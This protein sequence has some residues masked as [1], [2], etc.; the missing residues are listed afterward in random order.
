M[1]INIHKAIKLACISLFVTSHLNAQQFQATRHHFSTEDGLASNAIAQIVQDDYGYIWMATWNGLS[2]FDG[3]NF[4]NYK[5]GP[6]SHVRNLHN[7]ISQLEVDNQQNIWL[8][9]YDSRVFVMKRATD[10]IINPFEEISGSEDYRTSRRLTVTSS[11]DV[12]VVVDGVGLYKLRMTPEGIKSQLITTGDLSVSSIAEGY[13]DDIWLG[14]NQGVHRMDVSNLTIERKGLFLDEDITCIFSNGYNIY[15]GSKSGKILSFSYGQ[16]PQEI[17]SGGD[18]IGNL[19]VDSHG[20]IWFADSRMGVTKLDPD[21]KQEKFFTQVV[22][23]PD[24][25]GYGGLLAE[26]NGVVWIA[27]NRGGF[28][29]YNRERDEVEYFHNDPSNPWNLCNTINA[30]YVTN[31]GV[32]FE[33]TTRRGLEKLEIINK[34]IARE[35]LVPGSDSPLD[36]E[37]RG[38]MYDKDKKQLLIGNKAGALHLIKDDSTRSVYTHTDNGSPLGRIYGISKG[39]DGVYWIASKDNG[40]FKMKPT[41]NGYSIVNIRHH[42]DDKTSLSDNRAYYCVEDK[43]GNLWIATYGGGVNMLPKGKKEFLYPKRGMSNYPLNSHH[44]VRTVALDKDGKVWAGTTDGI[45]ILSYKDGKVNVQKLES[46]EEY[47]DNIMMSN[48]IICIEPDEHGMMWVGTNSGGLAHTIGQDSKGRW[49]FENFGAK[50]GLPSEEIKC[51]TF[52]NRGNVWFA[53]DHNICSY[54]IGKRIFATYSSL[55]GVDET[56]CSEA[57][58]TTMANGHILFGTLDG[59][60]NVNN[61][62]LI[63]SSGSMLKMRITDFWVND[64][65]QSPRLT[66]LYDYYVPESKSV[67]LPEH[68]S[69]FAFRFASLNYQLQHRVHYQYMLEGYDNEWIN[70]DKTR[71]ASYENL[72]AGTYT[73]KVKA[74]LI[75][76]PG[77]YDVKEIEVIVPSSFFFS[78]KAQWGYLIAA[79]VVAVLLMLWFQNIR[80][81]KERKA[82]QAKVNREGIMAKE[83]YDFMQRV[84]N[85]MEANYKNPTLGVEE[86]IGYLSMGLA[87]F[88]SQLKRLTG[89]TPKEFIRDYRLNKAKQMLEQTNESVADISFELGFANVAHF[90]HQFQEAMGM[91]PSQYR[92]AQKNTNIN[93]GTTEYEIIE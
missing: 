30:M 78:R 15:A 59:Y 56:I 21:T 39:S 8:R 44:K 72:P 36:N 61:D 51:L 68:D 45:L 60:Y 90:N 16:E 69:R 58:A 7:R 55:E 79:I 62:K 20:L 41:A 52:D 89:K 22:K 87:D 14:T 93:E 50:D 28:G 29:Y 74:F 71:I 12:L 34:T 6:L 4:Y 24:Y 77:K 13:Q 67:K 40:V 76:S 92:D 46:S 86:L 84:H 80:R 42:D 53:T 85:W 2:R 17:R 47:P 82:N 83:D 1:K 64:E 18:K 37:I 73:F 57:S 49:M 88:E 63:T 11:G 31:D 23:T 91:T 43:A 25:D 32:V 33:S 81:K 5:T 3:Y 10:C 70:A 26:K 9:M 19:F 35:A 54:D 48:D 65:I 38:L 27:M 66:S 75:N